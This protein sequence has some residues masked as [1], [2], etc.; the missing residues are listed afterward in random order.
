[1]P[2]T[3][4]WLWSANRAYPPVDSDYT[5]GCSRHSRGAGLNPALD[6]GP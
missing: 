1:M 4:Y 3:T 6:T 2:S 5:G